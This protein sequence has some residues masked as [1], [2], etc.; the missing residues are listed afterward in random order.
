MRM[1]TEQP[2]RVRLF[3]RGDIAEL[4]LAVALLVTWRQ[5]PLRP[6]YRL[7]TS[8]HVTQPSQHPGKN[9]TPG[10]S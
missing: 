4:L 3:H 10:V 8:P 9:G 5:A 2:D 7:T 1:P 6:A